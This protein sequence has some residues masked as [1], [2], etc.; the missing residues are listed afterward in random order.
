VD[1]AL[2]FLEQPNRGARLREL[3]ETFA[4]LPLQFVLK[5]V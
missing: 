5:W 3:H 1:L 2:R 4:D